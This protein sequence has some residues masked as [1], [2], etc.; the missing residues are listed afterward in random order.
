VTTAICENGIEERI[1]T[2]FRENHAMMTAVAY[3]IT[4]RR[5]YRQEGIRDAEDV[6]QNVFL[7]LLE[8]GFSE[9]M[10]RN[11]KGYLHQCANNE[12]ISLV[13]ARKRKPVDLGKKWAEVPIPAPGMGSEK[14]LL[15]QEALAQLDGRQAA[16]LLLHDHD[17]YNHSDIAK[18]YGIKENAIRQIV[19]RGRADVRRLLA[20]EK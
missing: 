10:M 6:I 9:E 8:H 17:G 18:M 4:Y 2:L 11:P 19:S 12:A 1:G 14:E 15:L 5:D 13:R 16:I 20:V 7:H 3:R